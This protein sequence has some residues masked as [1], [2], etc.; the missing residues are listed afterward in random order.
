MLD[1]SLCGTVTEI[2]FTLE[3]LNYNIFG[4]KTLTSFIISTPKKTSES[5]LRAPTLRKNFSQTPRKIFIRNVEITN[6]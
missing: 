3:L 2:C 1:V 6:S 5:L 4:L